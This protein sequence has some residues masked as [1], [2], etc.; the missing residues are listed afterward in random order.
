MRTPKH[1]VVR[2]PEFRKVVYDAE[3]WEKLRALRVRA[4]EIMRALQHCGMRAV[5]YGSIARGDVTR[6]SDIDIVI[7][8][9][10]EPYR[11]ELCLERAGLNISMKYIVQATPSSTPKAYIELDPEGKETI[12]F[13]L[14]SL[15]PREWEFY[16]FGGLLTL[17]SLLKN[18][19]VAGVS[20]NLILIIPSSEGHLEAPVV[21]Y[22][23]FTAKQLG[24][25]IETVLERIRV[26]KK[27]DRYGRT[28]VYLKY[29]LRP[30]ESFEEAIKDL[31]LE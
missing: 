17:E 3:R 23:G 19:R 12:S 9:V 5:A 8:Y 14:R 6:D 30:G 10:V 2:V 25:S 21:G 20:K 31:H 4:T 29:I 22:E 27:R 1:K 18:V 15:S 26:L 7:P 11:I 13:T 16:R 28:G 24:V